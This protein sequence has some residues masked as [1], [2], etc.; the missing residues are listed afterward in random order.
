MKY[1]L[2]SY[3]LSLQI[4]DFVTWG[5][6]AREKHLHSCVASYKHIHVGFHLDDHSPDETVLHHFSLLIGWNRIPRKI[7]FTC[8][9]FFLWKFRGSLNLILGWDL[10]AILVFFSCSN[11]ILKGQIMLFGSFSLC[12]W[13]R[14]ENLKILFPISWAFAFS[15]IYLTSSSSHPQIST[16]IVETKAIHLQ[17]QLKKTASFSIKEKKNLQKEKRRH[18]VK[19]TFSCWHVIQAVTRTCIVILFVFSIV[20]RFLSVLISYTCLFPAWFLGLFS[21][22]S[23]MSYE[24]KAKS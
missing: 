3:Y 22:L 1:I 15:T 11:Q 14:I 8:L 4:S 16:P 9:F 24:L 6:L 23:L 17:K 12:S 5:S 10:R 20:V 7:S 13:F 21:I 2:D 19:W 18:V